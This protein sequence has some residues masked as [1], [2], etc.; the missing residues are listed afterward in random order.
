MEN[1]QFEDVYKQYK[2]QIIAYISK[3]ISSKEDAEELTEDIFL[4]LYKSRKSY[5]KK[6]SSVET[7]LFAIANNRL[8]NYYRDQKHEILTNSIEIYE[9]SYEV[10]AEREVFQRQLRE[11][12]LW[13]LQK[14]SERERKILVKKYYQGKVSREIAKEMQITEG[15]VRVI[16][17]RSLNKLKGI[18]D[19][20]LGGND[21]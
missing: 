2:N 12:I 6:K 4:N 20:R 1:I 8:K 11:D 13:A 10:S 16:A 15:N 14:L 5:E 18:M 7:W 3:R 17:K 21:V 19:E 9:V